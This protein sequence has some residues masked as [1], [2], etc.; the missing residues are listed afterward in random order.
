VLTYSEGNYVKNFPLTL[1]AR[2]VEVK[3]ELLP[4]EEIINLLQAKLSSGGVAGL[5]FDTVKRAQDFF[6]QIEY[7]FAGEIAANTIRT[8]LFHSR[9]ISFDRLAKEAELVRALGPPL[10]FSENPRPKKMIVV[11]TQVL[12]QSLDIDFDILITDIAPIDLLLQRMGRLHRHNRDARPALLQSPE[13]YI[14]GVVDSESFKFDP[15]IEIIYGQFLLLRTIDEL[16]DI[17]ILPADIN[18]IVQSVYNFSDYDT[19]HTRDCFGLQAYG[20]FRK[21]LDKQKNDSEVFR[22]VDV[23]KFEKMSEISMA[24][25]DIKT[26]AGMSQSVRDTNESL[27]VLLIQRDSNGF[28]L[29]PWVQEQSS[30]E[31]IKIPI[32]FVMSDKIARLISQ[33]SVSLPRQLSSGWAID[34]VISQLEQSMIDS[35]FSESWQ[36]SRWLAGELALILDENFENELIV[37]EKVYKLTYMQRVGLLI[38]RPR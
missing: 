4:D 9:F 25:F 10:D 7:A 16:P 1:S 37:N 19:K 13:C 32:S 11:G 8:E 31:P 12:E 24:T 18:Q 21:K 14:T 6:Q 5:I 30:V 23:N 17:V 3:V 22:I 34:S 38:E 28:C 35:G 36:E 2:S 26:E 27:E 29:L 20:N 15:G 33:C